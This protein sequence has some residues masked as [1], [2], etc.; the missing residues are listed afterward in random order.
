M[1]MRVGT[2]KFF[3][4]SRMTLSKVPQVGRASSLVYV[5][6][7]SIMTKKWVKNRAEIN[8]KCH[9]FNSEKDLDDVETE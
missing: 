5:K 6:V 9:V 3:T 4:P 2:S 7:S 8:R 1:N